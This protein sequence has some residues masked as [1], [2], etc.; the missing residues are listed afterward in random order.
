MRYLVNIVYRGE[1]YVDYRFRGYDNSVE[2][3]IRKI[4]YFYDYRI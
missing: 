1:V 2:I 3:N 4:E